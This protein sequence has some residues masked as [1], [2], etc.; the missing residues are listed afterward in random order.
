MI[1]SIIGNGKTNK[2]H[3]RIGNSTL[4]QIETTKNEGT[5]K[6][7]SQR[8]RRFWWVLQARGDWAAAWRFPW[9][10][11][12]AGGSQTRRAAPASL[13]CSLWLPEADLWRRPEQQGP[14][15]HSLS[16]SKEEELYSIN[17]LFF[18]YLDQTQLGFAERLERMVEGGW[19]DPRPFLRSMREIF[20]NIPLWRS[21]I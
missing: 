20:W 1:Q 16:L 12:R 2:I 9:R 17:G 4:T 19:D 5:F 8:Y 7:D 10:Q 11:R 21:R 3:F 18:L 13:A 14:F 6:W 15:P